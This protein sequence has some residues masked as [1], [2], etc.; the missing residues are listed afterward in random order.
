[1]KTTNYENT[2]ILIGYKYKKRVKK[3]LY[4]IMHNNTIK[5][6]ITIHEHFQKFKTKTVQ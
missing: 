6:K 3:I 1:M 2:L 5:R 4:K